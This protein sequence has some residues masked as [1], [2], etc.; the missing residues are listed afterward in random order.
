[1]WTARYKQKRRVS[2]K[3]HQT[4]HQKANQEPHQLIQFKF[5]GDEPAIYTGQPS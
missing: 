1:M 3:S 5:W 2:K 4:I